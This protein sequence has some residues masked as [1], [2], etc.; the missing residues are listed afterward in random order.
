M[1]DPSFRPNT[2]ERHIRDTNCTKY[3]Y[4][5]TASEKQRVLKRA[6]D[7]AKKGIQ[8]I[9]IESRELN[10]RKVHS[11]ND[12]CTEIVLRKAIQNVRKIT[13]VRQSNRLE[14]VTRLRLL[15]EDEIDF[16]LGRFDIRHFF[17]SVNLADLRNLIDNR[18]RTSPGT[19]HVLSTFLNQIEKAGI[20]GLPT[21]FA[22]SSVLSEL[23]LDDFDTRIK[24]NFGS[25]FYARYVDDIVSISPTHGHSKEELMIQIQEYL[26]RG[27]SLNRAKCTVHHVNKPR[28][29]AVEEF[30]F[31]FLGYSF[32]IRNQKKHREVNLDISM[33]KVNKIKSRMIFS[34]LQY[35][36]DG[37]YDDLHDRVKLLT[38][39]TKYFDAKAGTTRLLGLKHSYPMIV[40][41]SDAVFELDGFLSR[42]F[43]SRTGKVCKPL[44]ASLS[45]RQRNKLLGFS[46]RR[47]FHEK[48]VYRFSPIRFRRLVNCWK[49]R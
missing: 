36:K 48:T 16:V 37:N 35:L 8:T 31:D 9:D 30:A 10:G 28:K 6:A 12:F 26:P 18:F 2:L 42:L 34:A 4:D 33:T 47:S 22:V 17:Q 25:Y 13:S 7:I 21:G 14:I 46:F 5:L 45:R 1:Y 20:S 27:L 49:Y 11:L 19:S 44:Y 41:P 15:C 32:F 23:Y 38:S 39:N 43:L 40:D 3:Q 29:D 24:R